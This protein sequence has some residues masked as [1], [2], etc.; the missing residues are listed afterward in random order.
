MNRRIKRGVMLHVGPKKKKS[1]RPWWCMSYRQNALCTIVVLFITNL[2]GPQYLALSQQAPG[3]GLGAPARS[4]DIVAHLNSVIQFYRASTQPIQE[5]G[6]PNDLVYR[7]QADELSAQ[8]AS[9]AFQSAKA[10]AALM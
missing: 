4:Q 2:L 6:E 7:D 8:I 9:F 3:T 5:A 1:H 10:E